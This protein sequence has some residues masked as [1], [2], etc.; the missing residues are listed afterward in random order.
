MYYTHVLEIPKKTPKVTKKNINGINYVYY[1]YA[2]DYDKKSQHSKPKRR[3][4]GKAIEV[5]DDTIRLNPNDTYYYYFPNAVIPGKFENNKRSKCLRVG[6]FIVIKKIIED[7]GIDEM[8]RDDIGKD[9]GL[10]LDF[11]AYSIVT[12]DNAGQYYPNYAYNH[13]LF[14]KEMHVY[15]DSKISRMLNGISADQAIAFLN[16]WNAG[17]NH[18]ER[19]YFSYDSTNKNVQAGNIEMAEYGK[20]KDDQGKTIINVA[21]A[22]DPTKTNTDS[23]CA[24]LEATKRYKPSPYDPHEF[25]RRGMGLKVDE[26]KTEAEAEFIK[27]SL[28]AM[29][30][31]DSVG[32]NLDKGYIFVRYDA[33]KTKKAVIR[34]QLLKM[35][36][37]P[38]NYYTSK[39][40]S[41][42]YFHIPAQ[43]ATDETIE[44]V[45]ALDGVDD[46]N[47]NAAKGSLAIT[48]VNT[49]TN[50]EK[51]FE[52]IRAEGIEVKK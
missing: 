45:L 35:G 19:I 14:T 30:G 5:T 50:P 22:Y 20:P 12:E 21:V 43:A 28:Y 18:R 29:V 11:A 7:Y 23:I 40:I 46:V 27:K 8:I 39:N 17:R 9:S 49:K 16:E 51:L 38:V 33:N 3:I 36:F 24:T 32:T 1:E 42:A 52:E 13:A 15:S 6:S 47:V 34:Q 37:T 41:F 31:M 2:R 10:F 4:I 44:K 25:I 48:Y 26:M